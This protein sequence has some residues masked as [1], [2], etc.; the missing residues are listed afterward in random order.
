MSSASEKFY[1]M[2]GGG[3]R[4]AIMKDGALDEFPWHFNKAIECEL[5]GEHPHEPAATGLPVNRHGKIPLAGR[6]T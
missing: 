4:K 3:C 2:F 6:E 1:K 5:P